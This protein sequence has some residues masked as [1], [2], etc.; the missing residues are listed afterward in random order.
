ML[1]LAEKWVRVRAV[2]RGG[3]EGSCLTLLLAEKWVRVIAV[4][5]GGGGR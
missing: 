4:S 1:L 2:S 3:E 5:S